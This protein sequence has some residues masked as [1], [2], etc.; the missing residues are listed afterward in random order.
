MNQ[1]LC[2]RGGKG[3]GLRVYANVPSRLM[4]IAALTLSVASLLGCSAQSDARVKVP[5]QVGPGAVIPRPV[6]GCPSLMVTY[7]KLCTACRLTSRGDCERKCESGDFDSCAVAGLIADVGLDGPVDS[8]LAQ[9]YF[10][11]GCEGG[12]LWACDGVAHCLRRGDV[13]KKDTVRASGMF[14]DLCARGLAVSCSAAARMHLSSGDASLGFE[15]AE[16]GCGELHDRAACVSLARLCTE[17]S[18]VARPGCLQ[19]AKARACQYGDKGS[20]AGVVPMEAPAP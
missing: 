3:L 9:D 6:E 14:D 2:R 7:S 18:S 16:K 11:R 1:H 20:C 5:S 8:T 4:G 10:R 19:R 15:Y 17:F 13:C 12:S